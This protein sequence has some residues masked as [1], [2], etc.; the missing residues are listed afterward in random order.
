MCVA[1]KASDRHQL[2]SVVL[3]MSIVLVGVPYSFLSDQIST[4]KKKQNFDQNCPS[5]HR[6]RAGEVITFSQQ[7]VCL[8]VM[9]QSQINSKQLIEPMIMI[10]IG[11]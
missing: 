8:Q 10:A 7:L 2:H 3:N 9:N 6:A 4:L 11:C 5:Y 1:I